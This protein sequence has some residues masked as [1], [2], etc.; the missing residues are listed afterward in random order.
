MREIDRRKTQVIRIQWN[1]PPTPHTI[2]FFSSLPM[3][4]GNSTPLWKNESHITLVCSCQFF[5][6]PHIESSIKKHCIDND[7]DVQIKKEISP[8]HNLYFDSS[9]GL[10][11][12]MWWRFTNIDAPTEKTLQGERIWRVPLFLQDFLWKSPSCIVWCFAPTVQLLHPPP[13]LS[14]LPCFS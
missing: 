7:N 12:F 10:Y 9:N 3:T 14:H 13:P 6:T 4:P 8:L 1:G 2:Q 5:V 11:L